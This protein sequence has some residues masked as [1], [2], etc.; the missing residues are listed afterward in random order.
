MGYDSYVRK[1]VGFRKPLDGYNAPR[2]YYVE[3]GH[4]YEDEQLNHVFSYDIER[5]MYYNN[6]LIYGYLTP[7]A[8]SEW[9]QYFLHLFREND[10][11]ECWVYL[12]TEDHILYRMGCDAHGRFHIQVAHYPFVELCSYMVADESSPD[13]QQA[14]DEHLMVGSNH[15]ATVF[16]ATNNDL[17]FSSIPYC[18]FKEIFVRP[19]KG[20]F[21]YF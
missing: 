11:N 9:E 14:E 21:D 1:F 12:T 7:T 16:V 15:E 4:I 3:R 13:V 20:H 17:V 19:R 6:C 5:N 18:K 10:N 2:T 8:N